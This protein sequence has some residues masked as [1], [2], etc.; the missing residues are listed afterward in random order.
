V[1][2]ERKILALRIA[3]A[4]P[5]AFALLVVFWSLVGGQAIIFAGGWLAIQTLG[6][7]L[8]LKRYGVDPDQPIL[9]SQIAI[10]WMMMI[11]LLTILVK[12]A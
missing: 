3:M 9:F 4:V 6:Y 12:S 7:G 8:I 2:R 10:H 1:T 5:Y 11:M